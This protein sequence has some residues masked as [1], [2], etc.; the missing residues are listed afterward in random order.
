MKTVWYFT[1]GISVLLILYFYGLT[2]GSQSLDISV[3][4]NYFW[5]SEK[6][7][8]FELLTMQELRIPR[9]TVALLAGGALAV[10][11]LQMQTLFRNPL[12]GPDVMGVNAGATLG[13]ALA[14]MGASLVSTIFPSIND[15]L[16]SISYHSLTLATAGSLGSLFVLLLL[17]T[18]SWRLTDSVTLLIL[19]LLF[20]YIISAIVSVLQFFSHPSFLKVF[21]V[22]TMGS[23]SGITSGQMPY[24]FISILLGLI[25]SIVTIPAMNIM[26]LGDMYAKTLGVNVKRTRV[27]VVL[28]TTLLSGTVTAFCGPISFLAIAVPH[29]CRLLLKTSQHQILLP[30]TFLLGSLLLVISDI[31]TSSIT[32]FS[33]PITTFTSLLG[34]PMLIWII[35]KGRK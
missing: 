15:N 8:D 5:S 16:S 29:M 1:L 11:G 20:S 22:W 13:V 18:V 34:I 35:I 19:G 10:S 31:V 30:A 17:F 21:V 12:A 6:L 2:I 3:V 28:S 27:L 26:L 7:M 24:L 14:V 33:L 32:S 25:L 9:V 23:T 4:F